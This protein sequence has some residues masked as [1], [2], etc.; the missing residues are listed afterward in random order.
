LLSCKK[1]QLSYGL[2]QQHNFQLC[3]VLYNVKFNSSADQTPTLPQTLAAILFQFK[4]TPCNA[5]HQSVMPALLILITAVTAQ[6]D[7]L[8]STVNLSQHC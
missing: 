1:A 5:I 8:L 4:C 2:Q 6:G 3:H 7:K